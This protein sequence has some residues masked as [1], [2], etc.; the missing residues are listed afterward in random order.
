MAKLCGA[1]LDLG[2]ELLVAGLHICDG[3]IC[4]LP[5]GLAPARRSRKSPRKMRLEI[6]K[7]YC[8]FVGNPPLLTIKN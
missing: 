2:H 7:L 3:L 4:L 1:F 5:G 6:M 8:T